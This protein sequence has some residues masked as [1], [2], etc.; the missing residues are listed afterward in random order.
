MQFG[1]WDESIHEHYE[2]IAR[3][4][5]MLQINPK[6]VIFDI[7]NQTILVKG[8]YQT[9]LKECTCTDFL[10][11]RLPCKHIY[12]LARELGYLDDLPKPN[13]NAAKAFKEAIPAEIERFKQL[14]YDGAISV[15]KFKKI[16]NALTSK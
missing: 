1:D 5:N 7:Q 3:I 14:Y 15:E 12:F 8:V 13:R 11:R 10:M 6:D 9:T 2:Q 16:A 4:G